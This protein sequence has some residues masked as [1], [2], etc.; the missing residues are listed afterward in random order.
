MLFLFRTAILCTQL[1]GHKASK[2]PLDE[3]PRWL[4]EG[5]I[6]S[7][8]ATM[9][10]RSRFGTVHQSL[11]TLYHMSLGDDLS[12]G[13]RLS[14]E[15]EP[16]M[17]VVLVA[18]SLFMTFAVLNLITGV[19]VEC[20]FSASAKEKAEHEERT[21]KAEIQLVEVG[22][23]HEIFK[24]ADT[25]N[26]GFLTPEQYRSAFQNKVVKEKILALG[27]DLRHAE[28]LCTMIDV[29]N[30][31]EISLRELVQ[32]FL[33]LRRGAQGDTV[34]A[35]H[36]DMLLCHD[37]VHRDVLALQAQSE[38]H[39]IQMTEMLA[40]QKQQQQQIA[41]LMTMVGATTG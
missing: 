25:D 32:G 23:C 18:F 9:I 21:K 12:F 15:S 38:Q 35:M 36:R 8:D 20:S 3:E 11:F 5:E 28:E 37:L 27:L 29:N 14:A 4:P 16:I 30:D 10:L 1:V 26:S 6:M 40:M 17:W 39:Q 41:D 2:D 34:S 31:G 22:I 19:I 33:I 24:L 13:I 7:E